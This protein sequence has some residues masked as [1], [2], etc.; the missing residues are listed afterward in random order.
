M[1]QF[2]SPSLPLDGAQEPRPAVTPPSNGTTSASGATICSR[3][4]GSGRL[5]INDDSFRTCLDCLGQGVMPRFLP[6]PSLAEWIAPAPQR[7]N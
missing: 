5:R 7:R 4:G 6:Q 3:C 1:A 2:S